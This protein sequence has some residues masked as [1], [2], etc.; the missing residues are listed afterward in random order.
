M[1]G[2]LDT[3]HGSAQVNLARHIMQIVDRR[4]G[5]V[6]GAKNLLGLTR[7]VRGPAVSHGHGAQDHTFLITQGDVLAQLDTLGKIFA[8]IQRDRHRPERTI[9]QTHVFNDIVVIRFAQ[10]S[11]ERVEAAIH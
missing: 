4:V 8:D 1:H 5:I 9:C 3:N 2:L 7:L 11:L 6:I 10:K